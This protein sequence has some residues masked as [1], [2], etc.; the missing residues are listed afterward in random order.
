MA[1]PAQRLAT[2]VAG[3]FFV[4]STCIDC[5]TCRWLAPAT[6]DASGEQS[7]VHRQPANEAERF[8]AELALVACPTGSI[9]TATHHDLKLATEAFPLVVEDEVH[10][11]GFHAEAS[12]GAASYLIVRERGNVLVDVP[13]WN[14]GLVKRIEALGGVRTLF[15]THIDDVAD[16]ARFAAHFGA[17]R[18]MH[19]GDAVAGI[20][21]VIEGV[22]P[23]ALDDDLV[24]VPT[25]GHTAG[26]AC[27]IHRAKFLFSGDHVAW[28]RSREHVYA[29][30][31]ACWYDWPTQIESM[32][33]LA[34]FDFEWILPGHGTRCRFERPR[35]KSEMARC[36]A[37]MRD[38]A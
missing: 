5:D 31:S 2:N 37:W 16:Q 29:F 17:E 25:P 15:L 23:V 9:G 3:D 36:V 19:S 20:E 24:V 38:G 4:D 27:L 13:R 26:S 11:L 8:A 21:R 35:M 33:R 30:R 10:H 22:E 7:R 28:S 14:A 18:V 6:F 32:E 12:F 1:S 34:A